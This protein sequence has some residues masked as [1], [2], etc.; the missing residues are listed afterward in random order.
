[1]IKITLIIIYLLDCIILLYLSANRNCLLCKIFGHK[2]W[3]KNRSNVIQFDTMGYPL[4]LFIVRCDCCGKEK[5]MWID[6]TECK[7]D[8]VLKWSDEYE[9]G[10]PIPPSAIKEE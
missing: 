9:N 8:V 4:R 10:A 1:M 6:S 7:Q 3:V 2:Y 5:M